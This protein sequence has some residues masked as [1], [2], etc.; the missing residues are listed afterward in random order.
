MDQ[1]IDCGAVLIDH[2]INLQGINSSLSVSD[3]C[4]NNGSWDLPKLREVLP[5]NVV[6]QVYGMSPPRE[7]LGEDRMV[8]GLEKDGRFSVK[9]AYNM[10]IEFNLD[11]GSS[12]W[13]RV[14]DWDGPNKGRHFHWLVTH[15][16]LMTNME[17]AKRIITVD[18]TCYQC[19]QQGEDVD[20]VLRGCDFAK[21]VW[22]KV[23]P[24]AVSAFQS[25]WSFKHWWSSNLGN[26]RSIQLFGFVAWLLWRRRNRMI[27][28]Q[29]SLG[30]EEVSRHALFW[31]Q[32][33]S[34][35]WKAHWLGREEPGNAR[36]TQLI[37]WR[38]GGE[39][40]FTLNTDGS[41]PLPCRRRRGALFEMT[42]D[43]LWWLSLPRWG[44]A[45]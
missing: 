33:W 11:E 3:F 41:L 14:W 31:V 21:G 30:A 12:D 5:E 18:T 36:Q 16:K 9:S 34:S 4:L 1:W 19:N 15:E 8:W 13:A 7:E 28:D 17:R 35:C 26:K 40:W 10:L 23:L 39:G 6:W 2:A 38:L 44:C 25:S 43:T 29:V 42:E 27:F 32:L 24:E 37:G 45:R 20:H 22:L